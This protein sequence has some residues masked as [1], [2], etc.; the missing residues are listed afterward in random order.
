MAAHKVA[1]VSIVK[2]VDNGKTSLVQIMVIELGR[3][4]PGS[5]ADPSRSIGVLPEGSRFINSLPKAISFAI[6]CKA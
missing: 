1:E 6:I 4:C 2:L 5:F 3:K